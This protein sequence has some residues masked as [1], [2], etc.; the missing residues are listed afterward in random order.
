V[1]PVIVS[2]RAEADE[3]D[4]LE[5]LARVAGP[6]VALAYG[7]RFRD[8]YRLLSEHPDSGAPRPAVGRNV[9]HS[10]VAPFILLYRHERGAVLVLRIVHGRRR[11]TGATL[12][13][14]S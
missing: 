7:H 5:Y 6:R 12:R 9:R 14:T 13:R 8:V 10:V 3:T 4:I 11:I 1:T 2:P